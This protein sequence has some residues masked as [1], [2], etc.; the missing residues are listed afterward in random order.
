MDGTNA[1]LRYFCTYSTSDINGEP[2]G[3]VVGTIRH[4]ENMIRLTRADKVVICFDAPGGSQRRRKMFAEYKHGHK[5]RHLNRH[6]D[7][8]NP[9]QN[10]QAQQILLREYLRDLPINV[11][12]IDRVEADDVI[13][14]LH[15]YYADDKKVIVSTDKD[16]QQLLDAH[17]IIYKPQKKSF[18]TLKDCLTEHNIHPKPGSNLK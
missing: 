2:N 9:E 10:K 13:A 8:K 6:Y 12:C 3:G 14:F 15:G 18:Y 4:I 17:T 7:I 5:P 16:F 1:F 11:L